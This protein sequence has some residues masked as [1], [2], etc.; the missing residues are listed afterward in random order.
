MDQ[1]WIYMCSPSQ[2]PLLGKLLIGS[3]RWLLLPQKENLGESLQCLAPGP[4]LSTF[5]LPVKVFFFFLIVHLFLAALVLRRCDGLQRVGA[6]LLGGVCALGRSGSVV[7]AWGLWSRGSVFVAC[8]LSCSAAWRVYPD[9]GSNW[10]FLHWQVNSG[11][12]GKPLES[13][14]YFTYNVRSFSWPP[15]C[16]YLWATT[17]NWWTC[18]C[19]LT[20]VL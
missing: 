1:P 16:S 14:V 13:Y 19:I 15:F 6:T 7:V 11:P 20:F 12:P 2:S 8:G 5:S 4:E 10:C 17:H 3:Y 18:K 9:Q